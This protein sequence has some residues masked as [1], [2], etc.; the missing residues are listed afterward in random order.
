MAADLVM[1]FV[2]MLPSATIALSYDT[3]TTLVSLDVAIACP[4][5]PLHCDRPQINLRRLA[6]APSDGLASVPSLLRHERNSGP[7]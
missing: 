7:P 6:V 3:A 5:S 1:H 2:G 4:V